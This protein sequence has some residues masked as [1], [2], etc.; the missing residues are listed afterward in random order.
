MFRKLLKHSDSLLSK[1]IEFFDFN[2]N[3]AIAVAKELIDHLY[4]YGGVGLAANQIGL[5]QRAF[6]MK[7]NPEIVCF[8]PLIVDYTEN[9]LVT[10]E[11]GCLSFPN[12]ILKVT[13]PKSIKVRYTNPLGETITTTYTG[14]TARIFQHELEHLNGIKFFEN[15]DWYEKEK[16]KSWMKRNKK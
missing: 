5:D 8:N 16:T 6:V 4:Y 12:L 15:V 2:K 13:R 7:G 9:D 10:L 1:E 3:D 11:E 14:M